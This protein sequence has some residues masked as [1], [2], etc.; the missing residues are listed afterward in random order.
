M[1]LPHLL[2]YPTASTI[3]YTAA[4]PGQPS[5]SSILK[6]DEDMAVLYQP[7]LLFVLPFGGPFEKLLRILHQTVEMSPTTHHPPQKSKFNKIHFP[8]KS[9]SASSAPSL[10]LCL[11]FGAKPNNN[12]TFKGKFHFHFR[13]MWKEWMMKMPQRRT[14]SAIHLWPDALLFHPH[15]P[16]DTLQLSLALFFPSWSSQPQGQIK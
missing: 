1:W 11:T 5:T 6:D 3:R 2:S 15:L 13:F 4:P 12:E 7:D 14:S 8:G 10:S 9:Y 16:E